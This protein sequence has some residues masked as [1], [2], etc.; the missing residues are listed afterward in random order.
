M[1]RSTNVVVGVHG[2]GLMWIMFTADEAVLLEIHPSYRED[3]HFRHIAR[4]AGKSYLPM[5]SNVRETCVGSSDS[6]IVPLREF[7]R[8]LDGAIRLARSY[9]DGVSECGMLCA[10]EILAMDAS[11]P[12]DII[13][14][15]HSR[16]RRRVNAMVPC[17]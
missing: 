7:A 15:N 1:M 12:D 17:L 16:P 4:L 14:S 5:R 3:R 8:A 6:V 9:D 11:I 2:A 10:P 13:P